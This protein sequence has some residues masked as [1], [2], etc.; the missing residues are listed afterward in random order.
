MQAP[1][2]ALPLCRTVRLTACCVNAGTAAHAPS[3]NTTARAPA[4]S[5][6]NYGKSSSRTAMGPPP[7]CSG[8]TYYSL[9]PPCLGPA[10]LV[11]KPCSQSPAV[12]HHRSFLQQS[13][14]SA[15]ATP[16]V[17]SQIHAFMATSPAA[18]A[19]AHIKLSAAAPSKP[20]LSS[21]SNMCLSTSWCGCKCI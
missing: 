16:V 17:A 21:K 5:T 14:V 3:S 8:L 1:F 15:P 10:C 20:Q 7:R 6:T 12:M 13:P 11:S 19:Y 18:P 2:G 4:P 9:V